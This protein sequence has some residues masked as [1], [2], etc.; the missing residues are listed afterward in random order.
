MFL[1]NGARTGHQSGVLLWR[2]YGRNGNIMKS[3]RHL[4]ISVSTLVNGHAAFIDYNQSSGGEVWRARETIA[5]VR[6][7]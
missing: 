1:L 6:G 2:A 5:R 3:S 4:A 7:R